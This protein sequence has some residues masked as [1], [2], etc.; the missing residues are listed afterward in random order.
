MDTDQHIHGMTRRRGPRAYR[1]MFDQI[2]K[3]LAQLER[4]V[5]AKDQEI[6]QLRKPDTVA[7]NGAL[8]LHFHGKLLRY[9][10]LRNMTILELANASGITPTSI[11]AWEAGRTLP[12]ARHVVMLCAALSITPNDLLL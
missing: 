9:R 4:D 12:N 6:R 5:A 3:Q 8:K 1:K 7:V 10:K 11:Y 2:R